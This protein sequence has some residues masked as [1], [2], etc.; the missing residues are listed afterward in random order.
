MLCINHRELYI[1]VK[2]PNNGEHFYLVF[3]HLMYWAG[4]MAWN[5]ARFSLASDEQYLKFAR[6]IAALDQLTEEQLLNTG[7]RYKLYKANS[8]NL[9][10]SVIAMYAEQHSEVHP[11]IAVAEQ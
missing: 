7:N 8:G 3:V 1:A 6:T 11:S 4:P 2:H 5:G 10:I 9:Q